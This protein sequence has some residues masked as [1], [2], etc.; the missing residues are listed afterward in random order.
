VTQANEPLAT[1]YMANPNVGFW[2]G[3]AGLGLATIAL[4]LPPAFGIALSF[5]ACVVAALSALLGD[6]F[7]PGATALLSAANFFMLNAFWPPAGGLASAGMLAVIAAAIFTLAPFVVTL[8]RNAGYFASAGVGAHSVALPPFVRNPQ[9]FYGG[10]ALLEL[11]IF[12]WRA[13]IELPGQQ[14]FAFGP[15]TAPRLFIMLLALIA[16]GIMVHG[17]AVI[18]PQVERFAFR[19]P[20]FITAGIIVFAICIRSVG[21]IVSTYLLVLV[22]AAG[23]AEV[24]W[25]ETAIWGAMLAAFSAILFPYVLNLPMQLWPWSW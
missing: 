4:P 25:L 1:S 5:V 6:R 10:V 7:F 11:A 2:L 12:A 19:G 15:G 9:D 3:L 17:L 23:S 20:F 18:G 8:L 24:R 14:G 16:I 21:L 13:S 22:S